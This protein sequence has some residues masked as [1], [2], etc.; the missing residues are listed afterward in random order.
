MFDD[1]DEDEHHHHHYFYIKMSDGNKM[2]TIQKLCLNKI[3]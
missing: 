2:Q 1:D 3:F